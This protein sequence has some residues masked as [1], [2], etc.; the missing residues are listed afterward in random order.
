MASGIC[1]P[2]GSWPQWCLD[3]YLVTKVGS[4][5][6]VGSWREKERKFSFCKVFLVWHRQF[7]CVIL[8]ARGR[9]IPA[10]AHAKRFYFKRRQQCR[11]RMAVSKAGQ[12]PADRSPAT[13]VANQETAAA[14]AAAR[15][16]NNNLAFLSLLGGQ[17]A[18]RTSLL[19]ARFIFAARLLV[20]A[21]E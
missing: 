19:A 17:M 5:E 20:L 10:I 15:E 13:R 3:V 16:K 7:R 6:I 4:V 21:G 14:K 2:T 12:S 9:R 8:R 18:G 1:R 11:T